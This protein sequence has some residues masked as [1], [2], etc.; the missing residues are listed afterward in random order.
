MARL[1]RVVA[2]GLPHHVTQ[3]RNRRQQVFFREEDCQASLDL[4]AEWCGREGVEAAP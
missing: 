1:T 2:Q 4:L 3:R